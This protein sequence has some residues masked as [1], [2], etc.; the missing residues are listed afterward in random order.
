MPS[1]IADLSD[2]IKKYY[3]FTPTEITN[4]IASIAIIAFI[5]SFNE[6][7]VGN[8]A[9]GLR[10]LFNAALI[11]T[12]T[13]IV[14]LS[15]Q[16]ITALQIGF[17]SEY[18]MFTFG[19]LL[20]LVLVFLSRGKIWWVILPGGVIIHHMAG[21]R[22]G[23][24][25][26]GL[27]YFGQAFIALM[28]PTATMLLALF[29]RMLRGVVASPL[30]HKAMVFNIVFAICTMLPIPPLDGNRIFW[31]S[32]LTYVFSYCAM[33]G[34]ALLLLSNLPGWI[35]IFGSILIGAI[36]WLLYYIYFERIYRG[37]P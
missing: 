29:F 22:L 37:K 8:L 33:I 7:E 4:V 5:I 13:F 6:W 16:R 28:G 10:N 27:T 21:H 12:L 11:V 3:K 36:C 26:Y 25:R 2:R 20:G 23:W 9:V 15:A 34:A 19:L 31:G 35:V 1:D 14:H 32:R 17:R 24:W 30:I 18:K